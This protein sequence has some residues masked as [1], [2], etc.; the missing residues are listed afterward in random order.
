M[1]IA[2]SEYVPAIATVATL[3]TVGLC[4]LLLKEFGPAQLQLTVGLPATV[5]ARARGFPEH[6]G[7]FEDI[8]GRGGVE[9]ITTVT[10]EATDVQE[11]IVTVT[12]YTPDAIVAT[13][14]IVGLGRLLVNPLGPVQL[15]VAVPVAPVVAIKFKVPP[16]QTG[17]TFA[18]LGAAGGPG[19]TRLTGP[20]VLEGQ[21]FTETEI[22]E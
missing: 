7:P 19:S 22:F 11:A 17:F 5:A 1:A 18:T 20:T 21:L 13:P 10:L 2:T 6:T 3:L 9:S 12:L 14:L 4:W 15:Q 8:V 16:L